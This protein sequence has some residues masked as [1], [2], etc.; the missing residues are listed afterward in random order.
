MTNATSLVPYIQDAF[1]VDLSAESLK[2]TIETK[3]YDSGVFDIDTSTISDATAEGGSASTNIATLLADVGSLCG[4]DC[5][6]P[7]SSSCTLYQTVT[8]N[9]NTMQTS[10]NSAISGI[11]STTALL[12]KL[13]EDMSPVKAA[14]PALLTAVGAINGALDFAWRRR[15]PKRVG[16]DVA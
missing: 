6:S 11:D 7:T 10:L 1:N 13:V 15:T 9:L 14:I 3:L 8:Q 2:V 16:A 5:T 4:C 12:V